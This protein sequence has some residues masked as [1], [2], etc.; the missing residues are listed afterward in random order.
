MQIK[1]QGMLIALVICLIAS[2]GSA[3]AFTQ[4]WNSGTGQPKAVTSDGVDIYSANAANLACISP[5]GS[6]IWSV[7]HAV[8]NN[9][10]CMKVGK[11]VF[12]GE[13]DNVL[14]LNK[15]NG[16]TKWTATNPL[17]SGQTPKY[18]LV[19]GAYVIVSNDA[20][21]VILNREDGTNATGIMDAA[22]TSQP[23]L[24]GGMYIGGTASGVQSY[25]AILL[26]DVR[27]KAI[28]KASDKITVTV[29]NIGL[30]NANGLL[31][32]FVVRKTDGTYRTIHLNA[33][34]VNAGATKDVVING[35]FSKGY[36]IVDPYYKIPELN[37][38][39]NQK[40]FS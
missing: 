3:A 17:G 1:R 13:G 40:Y 23:I 2:M 38:G 5:A 32:K 16:A 26:P 27:V 18:V 21:A 33:G 14:A 11:Y 35:A 8:A 34:T 24:F 4:A 7:S 12:I 10:S 19:K 29:E 36:V 28:N 30:S 20:K 37:E 39:N 9:G 31:V 6:Q 15:T 25:N 22:T